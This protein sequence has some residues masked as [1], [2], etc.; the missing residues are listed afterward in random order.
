MAEPA[1]LSLVFA[2]AV[3]GLIRISASASASLVWTAIGVLNVM[4]RTAAQVPSLFMSR[5]AAYVV[6]PPMPGSLNADIAG[7]VASAAGTAPAAHM[8]DAS[9]ASATSPRTLPMILPP[10]PPT[11]IN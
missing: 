10:P 9:I 2:L 7:T 6:G 5:A 8:P 4:V 1:A 11:H 3:P